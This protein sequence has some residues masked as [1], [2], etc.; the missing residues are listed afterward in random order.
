MEEKWLTWAKRLQ[1]IAQAGITYSKDKYDIERFQEIRELSSEIL[2]N[3]TDISKEKVKDLFCN[4]TG[5]Q[6]PKVDVRC[7]IFINDKILLVKENLDNK[8]SLPG[9]WAEVNLSIKENAIKESFEEAGI[10]VKPKKLIAL[11]DKS[12]HST[13]LNPYGIYKAFVL[14]EF[15]NGDFKENIETDESRLF[16]LDNLPTLST[17]RNNYDQI[18]MCFDFNENQNL[19]TIFD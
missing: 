2:S 7:A 19:D 5:Y 8:W 12:K 1:S 14:C 17:E 10:N 16:S 11:L 3:Y 9:G 6:T 18:K 15:I 4:E 13:T